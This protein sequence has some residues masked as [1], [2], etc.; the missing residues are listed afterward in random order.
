VCSSDLAGAQGA[1]DQALD[2]Q[3]ASALLA[4]RGLAVGTGVG[5]AWQH[6]VLGRYPALA[7]AAQEG[8]HLVVDAGG[9]QHAGIAEADEDGAFGMAGEAALDAH[10]A[11]LVGG[12]AT[13]ADDGHGV[14]SGRRSRRFAAGPAKAAGCRG[15]PARLTFAPCQRRIPT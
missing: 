5:G 6:A 13:G 3:R 7:L 14:V 4:A 15:G 9:A 12:A 1:A 11:Q 10:G 8:R 2:L